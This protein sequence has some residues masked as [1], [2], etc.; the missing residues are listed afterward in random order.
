M[1][2]QVSKELEGLRLENANMNHL[3]EENKA[4]KA[5]VRS[6]E[7][8]LHE[9]GTR[10]GRQFSVVPAIGAGL[11]LHSEV[12]ADFAGEG[13]YYKGK[14]IFDHGDGTFDIAYNDGDLESNVPRNR[15]RCLEID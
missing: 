13:E 12:E 8:A 5:Q 6:L 11:P 1:S 3:R 2:V 4:L 9:T 14:V 15:I 10:I 7:A